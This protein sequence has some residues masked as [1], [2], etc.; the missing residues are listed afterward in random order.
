MA[1]QLL[2]GELLVK[3]A[4]AHGLWMCVSGL[5]H[6]EQAQVLGCG[7]SDGDNNDGPKEGG[8][9]LSASSIDNNRRVG[10]S[11]L[12]CRAEEI[13]RQLQLLIDAAKSEEVRDCLVAMSRDFFVCF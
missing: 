13:A 7:G 2:R 6:K 10:G 9:Y 3:D 4:A 5:G 12:G 8:S 11:L 1:A